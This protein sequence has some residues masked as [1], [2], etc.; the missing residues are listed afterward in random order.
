MLKPRQSPN[1]LL[2]TYVQYRNRRRYVNIL[3]NIC[4]SDERMSLSGLPKRYF[5]K[6]WSRT[7]L[8]LKEANGRTE[9]EP[10]N[11]KLSSTI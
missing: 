8:V 3:I 11:L 10:K 1:A 2:P 9:C 4:S 7:L 6:R 5:F